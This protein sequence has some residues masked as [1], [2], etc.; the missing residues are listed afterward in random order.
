MA[1]SVVLPLPAF[2]V[3]V[4]LELIPLQDPRDGWNANTGAWTRLGLIAVCISLGLIIQT[5]EMV[6]AS[7]LAKAKTLLVSVVASTAHVI[8]SC[9]IASAWV[10]P[11]PFLS[12]ASCPNFA[13]ILIALFVFAIGREAF[14]HHLALASQLRQQLGIILILSSLCCIYPAFSAVYFRLDPLEQTALVLVLSL[15]CRVRRHI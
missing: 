14:R 8:I 1:V 10:F 9:S 6:P 11:I 15:S 2:F 3:A 7:K 4:L 13:C 12:V 5:C